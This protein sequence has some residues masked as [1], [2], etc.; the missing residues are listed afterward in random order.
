MPFAV[1]DSLIARGLDPVLFALKGAC[2]PASGRAVSPSLD[3]RRP[4]RQG[5]QTV[6]QRELPR[7]GF[8]RRAGAAGALRKSGSTGPRFASSARCVAA[9]RGGDD[10]LAVRHRPHP[11]AGRF[12]HGRDQ[13]CRPRPADAGRMRDPGAPDD[14]GRRRH[15]QGPRRAARAE[16]VRHRPGRHRDRRPCGRGRRH[17]GH[18]RPAGAGRAAARRGPDSRQGAGGACW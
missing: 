8:H 13:G 3:F 11:R 2:D 5:H 6:S 14:N 1:A 12:P 18:R 9:F 10:H 4:V 16:P 15:R 7:S 17:R